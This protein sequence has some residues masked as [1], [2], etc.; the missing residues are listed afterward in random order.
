MPVGKIVDHFM[1]RRHNKAFEV[2]V[3][4][5]KDAEHYDGP[6]S[7]RYAGL[8]QTSAVIFGVALDDPKICLWSTDIEAL[9]SAVM[10]ALADHYEIAWEEWWVV[11]V[12]ESYISHDDGGES[13]ELSWHECHIGKTPEGE[14][15]HVLPRF[16][17]GDNIRKG[18]PETST[19]RTRTSRGSTSLVRATDENTKALED[20]ATRLKLLRNRLMEFLSP[21]QIAHSLQKVVGLLQPQLPAPKAPK[22]VKVEDMTQHVPEVTTKAPKR[23]LKKGEKPLPAIKKP[24]TMKKCKDGRAHL[25]RRASGGRRKTP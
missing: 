4:M 17:G 8:Q 5:H 9:R 16:G 25:R 10:S 6:G 3:R 2:P 7:S 12:G 21:Q 20:F 22:G 15:V 1:F 19:K 24:K 13:V 23:K 11:E 14:M 18:W